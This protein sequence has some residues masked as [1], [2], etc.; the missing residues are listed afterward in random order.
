MIFVCDND[1][2]CYDLNNLL[3]V[4]KHVLL[5]YILYDP[6]KC[7]CIFFI[8]LSLFSNNVFTR[9]A[10]GSLKFKK[11][12][13]RRNKKDTIRI[14]KDGSEKRNKELICN[15]AIETKAASRIIFSTS[16]EPEEPAVLALFP[17]FQCY[18]WSFSCIFSSFNYKAR[19]LANRNQNFM[20]VV[21]HGS[22]SD[23]Q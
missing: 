18:N 1:L 4:G 13:L 2:N 17:G 23:S 21:R 3:E 8:S 9:S 16:K 7:T 5:S 11:I 15:S 6:L 10:A 19:G 12:L 22:V 14:H 20:W